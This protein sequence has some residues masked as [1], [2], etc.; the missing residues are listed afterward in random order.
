MQPTPPWGTDLP[1]VGRRADLDAL[2]CHLDAAIAGR[3]H[4]VLLTGEA[5]IGKSRLLSM[6]AREATARG[7]LIASGSA[8]ATEAGVAFGAV[9]DALS[10]PL[11]AMEPSA[12][13]V[14]ARGAED[15]L[16]AVVPGLP[17]VAGAPRPIDPDGSSRAR[18]LW[19]VTQ[20]LTRLAA[21]QPVVLVLDNAHDGDAS[22]LELL[23]FIARQVSGARILVVLSFLDEGR[24]SNPVLRGLVRSLLAAGEATLH[25]LTSITEPDL[26][27][28]LE[29]SFTLA[30]NDARRH[31]GVLWSHT[32][33]NPFFVEESLKALIDAGRI[34]H[35]ASGWIV[36]DARPDTLPPSLRDAVLARLDALD[37]GARRVADI[38]SVVDGRAP[39]EVLERVAHIDAG[40]FADAIDALCHRRILVEHRASGGAHYEF[41][42]P[43]IQS[44]VLGAMTAA[45][46][47]ALHAAVATALEAIHGLAST[48]HA[49][50]MAHHL[51]RGQVLGDDARTLRYLS[52]AGRD[53][54]S[55]RA[56]Q[57]AVRWLADAL[58][59]AERVDDPQAI[60]TLLEDL[61]TAQVRLGLG[62]EA[63]RALERALSLALARGDELAQVR[64][65]HHLGQELSRSGR[66]T[67]GLTHLATARQLAD[68]LGHADL[69]IRALLASANILQTL[70]RHEL[71]IAAVADALTLAE[72]HG[73]AG[74]LAHAHQTA[75]QLYAWT[76]PAS[77]A[78]EH[79][80]MAL[81]LAAASGDRDVEWSAHWAMA[82]LEGFSGNAAGVERH[83][84]HAT[85][86]ADALASP[87][88]QAMTAEIAIEHASGVGKWD[89]ALAIADRTIPLARAIMRRTLLPRLLVWTGLIVLER[90]DSE[91]ARALFEEAWQLSGAD[92]AA[93]MSEQDMSNVHNVILAHTGMGMYHL[94]RGDWVRATEFG[95]RGLALADRAQYVAWAIHR[96]I[97][98]LVEA[99][100][101]LEAYDRVEELT[102]R[103]HRD[104]LALN[105]TLGLAWAAAG[106]ALVARVQ[107]KA[108]DAAA[109]LLSAADDL[110]AVPF[111]FHA[112]RLRRNAAQVL[113]ADGDVEGATRELRRAHDVFARLGAEFELRSLRGQLRALGARLPPRAVA[114][115]AGALT[116]RELEIARAVAR[117]LSNK[118]IG[119]TL[120]IS[121]RTV[122]THLSNIFE[123]LGVDSR[124][125]LADVVRADPVLSGQ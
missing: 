125:A 70:G 2:R 17:G 100:L 117:R 56:D 84:R 108:P 121:A 18:L 25:T 55:R 21:R 79:G 44:T 27:E 87:F 83:V 46:E 124:G 13:T 24:E 107:F 113:E 11:R 50:A 91:R 37:D 15:D 65:H 98:M 16:R 32:R 57:E 90:D 115:G 36:E 73:D 4:C 42:H 77:K 22:S 67:E 101:R 53:A 81:S 34:R 9:A 78:R 94:S 23:H 6:L 61:A 112:A 89:E 12:V 48:E 45:R 3:G 69:A 68:R 14:L 92:R 120:D 75:L 105:H 93:A 110:D 38:A 106:E 114:H 95:E 40:A 76:G 63:L 119:A 80:A 5:G 111:I 54:L 96:L 71:A 7:V 30:P 35:A 123:K 8:F 58:Q 109:R 85:T 116:G 20:F 86:L 39:L 64:L 29:R 31:A 10:R 43:I 62:D 104:S 102:A 118:E 33:G 41:A 51:V 19:N 59:V 47:R 66:T 99:G 97:P 103:L 1:F 26:T 88:C 82:M 49:L 74:M 52:A 28:L 122:S 72:S 60:A